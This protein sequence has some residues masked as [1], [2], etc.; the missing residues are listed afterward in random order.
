LQK[1]ENTE[2]IQSTIR[3]ATAPIGW[4]IRVK[5]RKKKEKRH[6]TDC[7]GIFIVQWRFGSGFRFA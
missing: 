2:K 5:K 6:F 3:S 7:I 4:L 1:A